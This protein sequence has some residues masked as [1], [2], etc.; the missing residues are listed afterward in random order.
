MTTYDV[1]QD[2]LLLR[3]FCAVGSSL[4]I[5]FNATRLPPVW[6]NVGEGFNCRSP[7]GQLNPVQGGAVYLWSPTPSCWS[8]FTEKIDRLS[9]AYL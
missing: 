9:L 5:I 3:A 1:W 2:P 4:G 7:L 8:R 6:P